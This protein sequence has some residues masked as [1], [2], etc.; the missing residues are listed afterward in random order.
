MFET[1]FLDT[2]GV[3][4]TI[5]FSVFDEVFTTNFIPQLKKE[6]YKGNYIVVPGRNVKTLETANKVM[7]DNVTVLAIP[8]SEASNNSGGT[9]FYIAKEN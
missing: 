8:Y 5:N 9:T 2:K 6:N 1:K 7:T 4:F 3:L